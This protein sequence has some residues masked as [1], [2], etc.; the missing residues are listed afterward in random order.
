M[1]W[2]AI[3]AVGELI[4]AV[5]VVA[6][7][8]Y[9]AV[10]IRQN[11]KS[12]QSTNFSTWMDAIHGINHVHIEIADFLDDALYA[13]R[14]LTPDEYWKFHIHQAQFYYAIEAAYLF[15]MNGTVD[16]KFFE[17]RMRSGKYSLSLPGSKSWWVEWAERLYDERFIEYIEK[18]CITKDR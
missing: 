13:R 15:H 4:G 17:S 1:N 9:L 6:T 5:A 10:Q 3:G 2:E 11:T 14:E 8:I 12:V 16:D 18:N 7:L